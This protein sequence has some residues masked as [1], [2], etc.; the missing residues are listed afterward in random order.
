MALVK[1]SLL[2]LTVAAAFSGSAN[3]AFFLTPS[4]TGSSH[5]SLS[6]SKVG[7]TLGNEY[8][9]G[10]FSFR[11]YE[12]DHRKDIEAKD[13]FFGGEYRS[14]I[15]SKLGYFVGGSLD[16]S[17]D[18]EFDFTES[19]NIN[20]YGGLSYDL[21]RNFSVVGGF[22]TYFTAPKNFFYPILMAKYR[23]ANDLGLSFIAGLQSVN[24]ELYEAGAIDGIKNRWQELWHI[25]LPQMKSQ[26]LFGA[27][28]Q[29]TS[30]LSIAEVST[31][32]AGFPSVEYAGHTIITHLM[33]YSSIRME[34]GYAS[35]IATIL[36][37]IMILANIGVRK[38]LRRV[39]A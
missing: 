23:N 20:A 17:Y 4:F 3:A 30:A 18:E 11:D 24:K 13:I 27:V 5:D 10:G 33:D 37:L 25:T 31:N 22:G 12:F 32:L 1:K 15:D 39:G 9:Y 7:V 2:A 38:I 6:Y 8:V 35:A 28:M 36:F 34:M 29:I 21:G 26:L 19:Y 14:Q 16:F